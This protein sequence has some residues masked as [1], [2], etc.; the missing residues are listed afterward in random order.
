[1]FARLH[2]KRHTLK[3]DVIMGKP[4]RSIRTGDVIF[5]EDKRYGDGVHLP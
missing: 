2:M 1:M 5:K 3:I 4:S